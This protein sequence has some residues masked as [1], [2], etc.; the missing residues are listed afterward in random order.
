M[1]DAG[2]DVSTIA[3][4]TVIGIPY[5]IKFL[6]AP[7]FDRFEL[8]F[9]G[10]RRSILLLTQIGLLISVFFM[11]RL[12]PQNHVHEFA[13]LAFLVA[14]L[15]ASQDI[16]ADAFRTESLPPKE[17]GPASG[18]FVTGY[19]VA[20][21]V[22]GAGAM[23]LSTTMSWP[24]VYG[25]MS[26]A[27]LV[28]VLATLLAKEPENKKHHALPMKEVFT[29]PLLDF[30]RRP[31]AIAILSFIVLYKIGDTLAATL[32]TPFLK[33]MGY[34]NAQIGLYNKFVGA[35][36]SIVGAMAGGFLLK[37][38]DLGRAM[39]AFG[40]LQAVSTF[41]YVGLTKLPALDHWLALAIL[42]ENLAA[43]FGTAAFV[44]FMSRLCNREDSAGQYAVL[45]SFMAFGR[46]FLGPY[47]G[48]LQVASG[49]TTF[50]TISVLISAP[51]IYMCRYVPSWVQSAENGEKNHA[52]WVDASTA[53]FGMSLITSIFVIP[54]LSNAQTLI[55][56]IVLMGLSALCLIGGFF[57]ATKKNSALALAGTTLLAYLTYA[58]LTNS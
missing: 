9:L 21:L 19:R 8:K 42:I 10:R 13:I 56:R 46:V 45:S 31:A 27:L 2:V 6:W 55:P 49:W 20:M 16:V 18:T 15:S 38:W 40:I 37:K 14:L 11:S 48:P 29:K 51:G 26:L 22:S 28:G 53:F 41:V 4:F 32:A 1:K 52:S 25:F 39:W 47:A 50:F 44:V 17:L 3:A 35:A 30:F 7:F 43:G 24:E 36:G 54:M 58:T 23:T 34:S 57:N 33:E 12:D 5:S